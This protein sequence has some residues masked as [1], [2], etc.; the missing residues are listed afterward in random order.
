[1]PSQEAIFTTLN[2]LKQ[3]GVAIMVATHDLNLAADRFDLVMLLNR[4]LIAFGTP[5]EVYTR[6]YLLDAYGGSVH[7]M[8]EE[9]GAVVLVDTCC[10]GEEEHHR[11]E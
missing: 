6:P 1:M 9:D 2:E 4:R 3:D 10:E 8:S 5:D 11:L 7:V